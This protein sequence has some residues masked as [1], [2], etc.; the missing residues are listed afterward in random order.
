MMYVYIS[1][2]PFH[3]ILIITSLDLGG[4]LGSKLVYYVVYF[5]AIT[6][7]YY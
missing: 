5:T 2:L 6:G 3:S 1:L 7:C 4:G